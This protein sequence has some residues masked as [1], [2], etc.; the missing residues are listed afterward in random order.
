MAPLSFGFDWVKWWLR[1]FLRSIPNQR[2][3]CY[4]L[5]SQARNTVDSAW[6]ISGPRLPKRDVPTL[7]QQRAPPKQKPTR[8][9]RGF[10]SRTTTDRIVGLFCGYV[11]LGFGSP[12]VPSTR[13]CLSRQQKSPRGFS[14]RKKVESAG[15]PRGV[16]V[17]W[18]RL[19]TEWDWSLTTTIKENVN[20][21]LD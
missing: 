15:R 10:L 21:R 5:K 18:L 1:L 3:V 13:L 8:A 16:N 20:W 11:A 2:V 17:V 7:R 14:Q 6:L 4:T 12:I 19:T 9:C